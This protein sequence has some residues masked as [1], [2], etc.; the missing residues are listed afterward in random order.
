MTITINSTAKTNIEV[1]EAKATGRTPSPAAD[2]PVRKYHCQQCLYL[3]YTPQLFIR[4]YY[5]HYI[6]LPLYH[7]TGFICVVKLMQVWVLKVNYYCSI[8]YSITIIQYC[9]IN[10]WEV[11]R[12]IRIRNYLIIAIKT[13]PTVHNYMWQYPAYSFTWLCWISLV[14][15]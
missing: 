5:Y 4:H 8:I 1:P 6:R 3:P 15:M 11:K 14:Y 9:I 2:C 7:R 10:F 12:H 13:G